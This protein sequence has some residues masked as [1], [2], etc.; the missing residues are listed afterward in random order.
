MKSINK[1]AISTLII[2]PLLSSCVLEGLINSLPSEIPSSTP[3]PVIETITITNGENYALYVGET[4]TLNIDVSEGI[5]KVIYTTD[6]DCIS[7]DQQGLITALKE[8]SALVSVSCGEVSDTITIDVVSIKAS[9]VQITNEESQLYIGDTLKLNSKVTPSSRQEGVTYE[10]IGGKRAATI[11]DDTLLPLDEGEV[12]IIAKV[13][14]AIS[15]AFTITLCDLTVDPYTNVNSYDFYQNYEPAKSYMDAYYRSAH[16]LMSGSIEPQD[17][18]PT[19]A[20]YQPKEEGKFV[21]NISS[22]YAQ[23]NN[24]YYVV[25]GYGKVVNKIYKGGAYVSLEDVA[26]YLFAFNDIPANYTANKSGKPSSSPWGKYL[27]VNHS[28]FSGDTSRYPYEPVL[29]N[30]SG[31]G[32]NYS[33]FELDIGTTGTDC[34]PSYTATDYNNG[35]KIT[36]GAARI[37]YSRFTTSGSAITNFSEKYLFYTYN[38]YNDFQEYLNYYGGWGEMFGNVTGGGELSSKYNYNPTSY[39]EVVKKALNS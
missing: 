8:G 35:S 10:I 29:P 26:A 21:K 20:S 22:Y 23:G 1:L 37:V 2:S 4:L 39:V 11:V 28:N 3:I 25:D 31:C 18:K 34:D 27:R 33:Y 30:I 36:R 16:N 13:D 17:Q 32:G 6:S 38:H 14:E 9:E 5:D 12:T 15:E 7:I 19:A 24:A